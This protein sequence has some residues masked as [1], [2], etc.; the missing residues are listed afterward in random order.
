MDGYKL[1][2][3]LHDRYQANYQCRSHHLISPFHYTMLMKGFLTY[4]GTQVDNFIYFICFIHIFFSLLSRFINPTGGS[5]GKPI[6]ILCNIMKSD[7]ICQDS[8]TRNHIGSCRRI[9]SRIR[10]P[11]NISISI[12]SNT[13]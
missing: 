2:P 9:D 5:D 7:K 3:T 12:L 13:H 4:H 1:L 6:G 10:Q 11:R 8:G